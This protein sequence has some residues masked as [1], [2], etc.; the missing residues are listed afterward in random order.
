MRLPPHPALAVD[1]ERD[2][3]HALVA[4]GARVGG[5]ALEALDMGNQLRSPSGGPRRHGRRGS[6][7]C[8]GHLLLLR[9]LRL[10]R[11][12][13]A[14]PPPPVRAAGSLPWEAASPRSPPPLVPGANSVG[15]VVAT[16]KDS[17]SSMLTTGTS[18]PRSSSSDSV[19]ERQRHGGMGQQHERE[20]NAPPRLV[21]AR[22]MS[23]PE[24]GIDGERFIA[25]PIPARRGRP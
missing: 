13:H 23:R 21:A 5:I 22:R 12:R 25:S 1:R 10:W 17:G 14:P 24:V 18:M 11:L 4:A 6:R 2:P 9:R 19:Q 7:R 16:T 3:H 8:R 15:G 20:A